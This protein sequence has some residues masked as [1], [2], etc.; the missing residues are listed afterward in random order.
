MRRRLGLLV[1]AVLVAVA[2]CGGDSHLA[3]RKRASTDILKSSNPRRVLRAVA[4]FVRIQ[5]QR[6][7]QRLRREER[8]ERSGK[9]LTILLDG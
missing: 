2:G 6:G 8:L 3:A 1:A 5:G 4:A 7:H 9:S